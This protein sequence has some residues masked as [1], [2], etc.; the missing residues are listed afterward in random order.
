[1]HLRFTDVRVPASNVLLGEGRGFEISPGAPRSRPHPPLHALDRRGREGA[2]D[3][4]R[5]GLNREASARS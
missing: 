1:M 3:D 5:R 2:R 4:G